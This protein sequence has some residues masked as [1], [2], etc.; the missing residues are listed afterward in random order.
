MSINPG[1]TA[2]GSS[3][4]LLTVSSFRFPE[5]HKLKEELFKIFL[6]EQRWRCPWVTQPFPGEAPLSAVGY[7]HQPNDRCKGDGMYSA[8]F[9]GR[10]TSH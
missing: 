4:L 2:L 8:S 9:K 7:H 10:H 5:K 1:W 6:L 3:W